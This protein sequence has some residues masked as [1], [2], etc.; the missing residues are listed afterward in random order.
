M[1]WDN[2][3]SA[4]V[5]AIRRRIRQW[6]LLLV[7]MIAGGLGVTVLGLVVASSFSKVTAGA[8]TSSDWIFEYSVYFPLVAFVIAIV[9]IR[10]LRTKDQRILQ[11]VPETGGLLCPACLEALR[12]VDEG[13]AARCSSCGRS[14]TG[15]ALVTL[16]EQYA[17]DPGTANAWLVQFKAKGRTGP[18]K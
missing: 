2:P 12:V 3:D 17:S 1:E 14:E 11:R 10:R 15:E 16:W 8:G 6:N 7:L 5:L 4:W 9:P 18:A 13:D